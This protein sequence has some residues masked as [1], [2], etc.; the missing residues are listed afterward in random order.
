MLERPPHC[1][2]MLFQL[3]TIMPVALNLKGHQGYYNQ[4]IQRQDKFLVKLPRESVCLCLDGDMRKARKVTWEIPFNV[5]RKMWGI[6]QVFIKAFWFLF[7]KGSILQLGYEATKR[8]VVSFTLVH[9]N[10]I[11]QLW[12]KRIGLWGVVPLM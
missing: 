4:A 12:E 1:I 10:L 11:I 5:F 9:T 6:W 8:K 7:Q 3:H 2:F